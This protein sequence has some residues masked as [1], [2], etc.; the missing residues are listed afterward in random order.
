MLYLQF[1]GQLK[2]LNIKLLVSPWLKEQGTR[3]LALAHRHYVH[4]NKV[5]VSM[6]IAVHDFL[7]CLCKIPA[8][9]AY[10]HGMIKGGVWEGGVVHFKVLLD[11]TVVR[12][13][14]A[15]VLVRHDSIVQRKKIAFMVFERFAI[16]HTYRASV[17][18]FLPNENGICKSLLDD[19]LLL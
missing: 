15:C 5:Y 16:H 19:K 12:S 10:T 7:L 2:T 8:W 3:K 11:L 9:V 13:T 18:F 1:V 6:D 14:R 17:R 4:L